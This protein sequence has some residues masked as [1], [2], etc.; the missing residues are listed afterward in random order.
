VRWVT[1]ELVAEI[2]YTERTRDGRLRHPVYLGLRG[3]KPA[4]SVKATTM[5]EVEEIAE[6]AGIKLSSPNKILFPQQGVSKRDLAAYLVEMADYILPFL[7]KRP[8]SLV[9]CPDGYEDGCFFQKHGASG[10]PK[11]IKRIAIREKSGKEADY[12]YIDDKAGLAAAAQMGAL[13][14]HIWGATIS[15]IEKPDRMVFDLDPAEDVPFAEVRRAAQDLRDILAAAGL[16]SVPLLT[17]GK[18][19][20]VVVPLEQQQAWDTVK[21]FA[22]G[23][24]KTLSAA[25][26]DRFIAKSTKAGRK[27][28]IFIDWLRNERGATAIVPYSPR[29][30]KGAPV[31]VP[32]TWSELPRIDRADKYN[33][34]N[35]RTRL[36]RLKGNPW[37]DY[38]GIRQSISGD[39]L[40]FVE[41]NSVQKK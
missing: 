21:R 35:V 9:R 11:Q 2:A 24:A 39:A 30:R 10:F 28:R 17:G 19:I 4:K 26:P 38:D 34:N 31:A 18:G 33:M 32:V 22:S 8:L 15:N 29:A 41:K 13:E 20:H 25:E 23:L 6:F 12:L 3:D 14:F 5:A 7:A 40:E 36:K 37:E 16:Q 27:G 1:P